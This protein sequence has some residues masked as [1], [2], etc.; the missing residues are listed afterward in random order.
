[1]SLHEGGGKGPLEPTWESIR[2]HG[3]GEAG[4]SYVDNM[5]QNMLEQG[6]YLRKGEYKSEQ[7]TTFLLDLTLSIPSGNSDCRA[8]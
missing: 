7:P 5:D 8:H 4:E 2:P 3:Q 1:M 6:G